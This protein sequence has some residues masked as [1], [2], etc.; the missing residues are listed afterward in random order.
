MSYKIYSD[1]YFM[2]EALKEALKALEEEEI[3]VGAVIVA[4]K[5]I[6]A[7]AHNQTELLRDVTAHAEMLAITAAANSLGAKYLKLCT[8]YVTLEPC[9]MCA[10]AS[11]WA[12]LGRIV[13]GAEDPKA[14]YR[15]IIQ[16][17]LH[18]KTKIKSGVLE[19]ECSNLL[20][21]FFSDKR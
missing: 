1:E 14:G 15:R 9:T 2:K 11:S 6:I 12:Q 5:R 19:K 3:P 10:S 4:D 21:D 7:R 16:D 20:S 18:P 17:V 13:F 8:L